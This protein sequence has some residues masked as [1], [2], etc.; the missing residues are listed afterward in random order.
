MLSVIIALLLAAPDRPLNTSEGRLCAYDAAA[1]TL[2]E[3]KTYHAFDGKTVW[4]VDVDRLTVIEPGRYVGAA[5][6]PFYINAETLSYRGKRY[7]KYGLPRVLS[8]SDL[9]PRPFALKD[10]AAF[11]LERGNPDT[12]IIYLLVQPLGCEFQPYQVIG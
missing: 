4:R 3:F 1:K 2:S 8:A 5:G 6:S 10:G 9:E 7:G 12:E 11:F